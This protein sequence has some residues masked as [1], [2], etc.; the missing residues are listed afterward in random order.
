MSTN[1]VAMLSLEMQKRFWG[2]VDVRGLGEC[3]E[4]VGGRVRGYG[5]FNVGRGSS[6]RASR[7]AYLLANGIEPK[8]FGLCVLHRCDNPPCCNPAHL[9]AGTHKDNMADKMAKGRGNQA[10]GQDNGKARLTD[11]DV[12]DVRIGFFIKGQSLGDLAER[13]GIK[14][15][16][17]RQIVSG[18]RWSH[19]PLDIDALR[20]EAHRRELRF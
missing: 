12:A 3:W 13:Y 7:L 2:Y 5:L 19:L 4:W 8:S 11:A 9:F 20:C 18:R 6:I 15:Q 17:I 1:G 14:I 16:H 10:K